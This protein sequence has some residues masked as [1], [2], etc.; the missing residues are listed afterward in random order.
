ML[1]TYLRMLQSN[2]FLISVISQREARFSIRLSLFTSLCNIHRHDTFSKK[3]MLLHISLQTNLNYHIL[4]LQHAELVYNLVIRFDRFSDLLRKWHYND[5]YFELWSQE[6]VYRKHYWM[7]FN[8][9]IIYFDVNITQDICSL[10]NVKL[11]KNMFS[12]YTILVKC[13]SFCEKNSINWLF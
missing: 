1:Y 2:S 7:I 5:R 3:Q 4:F 8:Y 13:K 11:F 10:L 6:K 9:L 12:C